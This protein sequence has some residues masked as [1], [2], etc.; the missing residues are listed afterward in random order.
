MFNQKAIY[1]WNIP[2][3][4]NGDPIAITNL[5]VK[6]GFEAIYLKGADG[7]FYHQFGP[8]SAFPT[9]G[10][11]I[12][13]DLIDA[14]R[15]A[16]IKIY[17]WQFN[18]GFNLLGEYTIAEKLCSEF[19]PDGWIWDVEGA[20][21]TQPNAVANARMISTRLKESHPEVSQALCWWPLPLN[22]KNYK[23]EWH[24]IKVAKAFMEVVDV[25]MPMMYWEGSTAADAIAYLDKSLKI[26]KTFCDLPMVPTGRAYIGNGGKATPESITAFSDRVVELIDQNNLVGTSWWSLD[27][28]YGI[29]TWWEA[30]TNTPK[31]D[32]KPLTQKVILDRLVN[33]HQE[34]FP[35]FYNI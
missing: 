9:W 1:S 30:L 20:F 4:L 32:K 18:Y 29:S 14:L 23:I 7:P 24:P 25:V 3:V 31:F 35:E 11:N 28:A 17:I 26:W 8:K 13:Q 15:T 19:H 22:P 10:R 33:A 12:H 34:L 21:D 27:H 6:A 5:L 16:G 2:S